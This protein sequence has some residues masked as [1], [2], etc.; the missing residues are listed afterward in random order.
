MDIAE[1]LAITIR[2]GASDLHL[3]VGQ[4]PIIRVHGELQV[5]PQYTVISP[6]RCEEMTLAIMTTAQRELFI[7]EKELDF[8][9]VF[10]DK[11]N[12]NAEHRFRVNAYFQQHTPA[13]SLRYIPNHIRTFDELNLP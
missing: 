7:N 12:G 2:K 10:V 13:V 3:I 9:Y 1:L 4:A 6:E 8:S 5:L 11:E